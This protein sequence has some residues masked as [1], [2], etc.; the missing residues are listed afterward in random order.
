M[1]PIPLPAL[2]S[3]FDGLLPTGLQW[4]WRADFV[5]ELSDEAIKKH[6]SFGETMPTPLSTMHL[7]PINGA[8]SRVKN[9]DTAWDY[10]DA[11][12]AMVIVGIDPDPANKEKITTWTKQYWEA[13]HPYSAGGAYVNFMMDEG[14]DRVKATYGD[15]YERLV[16]IKNKYDPNNLFRVNQNIK[17]ALKESLTHTHH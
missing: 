16:T 9:T 4:Y 13:L 7:Y 11:T 2:Q 8:V 12:W 6:I 3:L 17:P 14:E 15:N 5:N 1:G 10:R